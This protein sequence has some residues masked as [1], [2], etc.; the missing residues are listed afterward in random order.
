[1]S[2]EG[3]VE[4]QKL[5][6]TAALLSF[7][8][9]FGFQL[10]LLEKNLITLP[11]VTFT[12]ALDNLVAKQWFDSARC[13]IYPLDQ[14][15]QGVA[16]F[17]LQLEM[18]VATACVSSD[19]ITIADACSRKTFRAKNKSSIYSI[20]GAMLQK[21]SPSW[22]NVI[23]SYSKII[24]SSFSSEWLV[25]GWLVLTSSLFLLFYHHDCWG[26]ASINKTEIVVIWHLGVR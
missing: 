23:K 25:L 4:N 19:R 22:S 21:V 11:V 8:W 15:A 2:A 7:G 18:K 13:P 16:L 14:C 9:V 20:A 24:Y 12:F 17:I 3:R 10:D 1:M 6:Q 26:R 5:N